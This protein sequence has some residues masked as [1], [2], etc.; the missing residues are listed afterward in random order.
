MNKGKVFI[1]ICIGGGVVLVVHACR[2]QL[3]AGA[4]L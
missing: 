4:V 1:L 3:V 2:K